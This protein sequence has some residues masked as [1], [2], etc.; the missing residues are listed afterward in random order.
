MSTY[1][2]SLALPLPRR[3]PKFSLRG[4]TE[5]ESV[6]SWLMVTPPALFLLALVGYPFVYGI[7]LSLEDK[8]VAHA[9]HFI[10][11][12][13]FV[14]DLHDPVFW[15]VAQNTF[16]YTFC[17]TIL[18]MLGGLALALVM[19]QQ[20][21]FKNLFRAAMLLP[22]IVPTV[23]STI[24]WMWILDPSFSVI[25]WFLIRWGIANPGPSWLGN[26]HLAMFSLIMVNTW[27]GLPFYAITL[28]AGLQT[29]SPDL[30]EAATIDG[31][32]TF[33]RFRYVTMPLLK[34]VIFIV[35]MFSV[36]FTFSD[37]QL[38]Y[39]LTRGGPANA[40]HLF[41]TYAFDVAM[42][43]GQFGLGASIALSML[44]PLALLIAGMAW[45]MRGDK[46]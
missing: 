11:L 24:A 46:T 2:Q 43:G 17:A 22:F 7:W 8:P 28:L 26:P 5:R 30:Y 33:A 6:F 27:R 38:V 44:P 16:V 3:R 29:I 39:V 32:T 34:P 37:F 20:F 41:A 45:Y 42:S 19:N 21:R 31:A 18:K 12:A 14:T 1:T 4:W 10:G 36:I 15:Q 13:N 23:L 25:N 35:T 40:T 9:G